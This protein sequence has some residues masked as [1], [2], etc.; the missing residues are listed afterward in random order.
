M[1]DQGKIAEALDY[2]REDTP[3]AFEQ[4]LSAKFSARSNLPGDLIT[5]AGLMFRLDPNS[6]QAKALLNVA[7]QRLDRRD[8]KFLPWVDP[9][10]RARIAAVR[11]QDELAIDFLQKAIDLGFRYNWQSALEINVDFQR[12]HDKPRY[13]ELVARIEADMAKQHERAVAMLETGP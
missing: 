13:R 3:E 1:V 7:G 9:M 5:I 4:P 8:G 2:W 11:G 12:L 10:L 6:E